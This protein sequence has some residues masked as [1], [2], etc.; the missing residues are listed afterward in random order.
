MTGA[1]SHPKDGGNMKLSPD[2]EKPV[3]ERAVI[4]SLDIL[5]RAIL[6][7]MAER[8]QIVIRDG[9]GVQCRPS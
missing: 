6:E 4:N 2:S 5:H 3:V 1:A 8:G 7:V 9:D